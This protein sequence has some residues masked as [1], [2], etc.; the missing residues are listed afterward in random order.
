MRKRHT[1]LRRCVVCGEQRPKA[2]LARVVRAPEGTVEV[3]AGPKASGRGAYV[4]RTAACLAGA[5]EGKQ[6]SRCLKVS[7]PEEAAAKL[8]ELAE[9]V[10]QAEDGR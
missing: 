10:T 3:D 4:C 7:L 8:R 6:L 2:D 9:E 1:P 5:A